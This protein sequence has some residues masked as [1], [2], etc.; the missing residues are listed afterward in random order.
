MS[1]QDGKRTNGL[2]MAIDFDGTIVTHDYPRIGRDVG[3]IPH[4]LSLQN[5]GAKLI[6]LTMRDGDQ[7]AHAVGWCK[8]RGLEFWAINENPG[9]KEWTSSPKV[10]AHVYVDDNGVGTPLVRDTATARPYVDWSKVGP[11]L[12]LRQAYMNGLS[13]ADVAG[14]ER[15]PNV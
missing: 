15:P 13:R 6:L 14:A 8:E 5:M 7:L 12:K 1:S 4:L 10:Y 11:T 2:I 9:Q 3:A